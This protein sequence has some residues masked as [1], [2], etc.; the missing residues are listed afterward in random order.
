MILR[1]PYF[2]FSL[3][4]VSSWD[5]RWLNVWDS[6]TRAD[7]WHRF[8]AITA[9]DVNDSICRVEI[10]LTHAF[11][12]LQIVHHMVEE[13]WL[14]NAWQIAYNL[15]VKTKQNKISL[16]KEIVWIFEK[17]TWLFESHMVTLCVSPSFYHRSSVSF[18]KQGAMNNTSFFNLSTL[19]ILYN[20]QFLNK[21]L[22][23]KWIRFARRK[24]ILLELDVYFKFVIL[25]DPIHLA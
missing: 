22:L 4:R 25:L 10:L 19:F 24:H 3:L 23:S 5:T 8:P 6:F 11:D 17:H 13:K 7:K 15:E 18:L 20:D 12:N 1:I 14:Q 16:K 2:F 21:Y 9:T